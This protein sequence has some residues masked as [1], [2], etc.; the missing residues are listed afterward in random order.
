MSAVV[1]KVEPSFGIA[2]LWDWDENYTQYV[3]KFGNLRSGH[4]IGKGQFS[5]LVSVRVQNKW[6]Q[7]TL[8]KP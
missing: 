5:F 6:Y 1:G 3:S 8:G 7:S 2:L 4:K